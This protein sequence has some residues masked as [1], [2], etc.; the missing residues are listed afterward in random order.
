VVHTT[1]HIDLQRKTPITNIDSPILQIAGRF[2]RLSQSEA[3]A[4]AGQDFCI[5]KQERSLACAWA[6]R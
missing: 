3:R 2:H 1:R 4:N 6:V 5:K